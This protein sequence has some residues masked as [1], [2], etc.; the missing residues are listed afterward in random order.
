MQGE[1]LCSCVTRG[2]VRRG[3]RG[4]KHGEDGH[5]KMMIHLF[6]QPSLCCARSRSSSSHI[7]MLRTGKHL[8]RLLRLSYV[9]SALADHLTEPEQVAI[10]VCD[11]ELSLTDHYAS[12][13]I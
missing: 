12:R 1:Q 8:I 3:A 9:E 13:L 4:E 11:Q 6:L 2:D 10:R 7:D 5:P